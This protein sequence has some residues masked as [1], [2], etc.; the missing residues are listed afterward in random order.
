MLRPVYVVPKDDVASGL[1]IPTMGAATAV[2]CMAGFFSSSSFTQLAP[3]LAAFLNRSQG[4]FRLLLS[5]RIDDKDRRAIE[6]ATANPEKVLAES[7]ERL[8]KDG[9]VSEYALARHTV[10]CLSYLIASGR[11]EL[12]IVLTKR[13]MFHPK[14]WLLNDDKSLVIAHGSSN[15]TEP[16]LLFNFETVSVERSWVE[17]AK[18]EFFSKLFEEVWEGTDPTT[19]TIRMPK[20]LEFVKPQS[21]AG[22]CPTVDDYWAA[23]HEDASKGLAPPLPVNVKVPRAFPK[24]RLKIPPALRWDDGP[25]AHQGQ[26]VRA[27]EAN[28][29][30]ILAIATGGGKTIASLVAATRLQDDLGKL[31]LVIAAPYKPLVDQWCREVRRFGVEPLPLG[32]LGEEERRTRL[33][34]A[35]HALELGESKVEVAVVTNTILNQ[36]GFREFLAAVPSDISALLI[37]DE[38][39]N[40]GAPGFAKNPAESFAFRLGLSATPIRQYDEEGTDAILRY[41]GDVVFTFDLGQAIRAGCLTRY[42]YYLHPVDLNDAEFE[43]WEEISAKLAKMGFGA[44]NDDSPGLAFDEAKLLLLR[45]RSILENAESKLAC[46]RSLLREQRP[47]AVKNTLIYTSAKARTGQTKQLVQVNRLLNELGIVARELTYHETGSGEAEEILQAFSNGMYQAITCMKVLDEGV[48]IPQTTTAYLMASSTVVREWVQ[49]RGR[50]LRN[51]PGKTVAHL[52][53]FLV[54]PPGLESKTAR[55][56]L[57]SELE[58][59]REF[60]SLA[61]NSGAPDGPLEV[62]SRYEPRIA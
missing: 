12:R 42:H 31:L 38:V 13:G 39:H 26:A 17:T 9:L 37:A 27:W 52:H 57:R 24:S 36:Q 3:G 6:S 34:Q 59:A 62:M 28:R 11:A 10:Q 49:R 48:D 60:A 47:A 40:L 61:D 21:A 55:S 23:W 32:D 41:F 8:F 46:L 50:I 4:T 7:T 35:V 54:V 53:D 29:R 51:A 45:R 20:G 16:G 56:V 1:L 2:R 15:P 5:P 30:G 22:E 14:V 58:R 25:Y 18:A 44:V 19:L 33:Q 43:E